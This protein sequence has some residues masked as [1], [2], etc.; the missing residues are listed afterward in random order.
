MRS[1][2]TA[3][4]GRRDPFKLNWRISRALTRGDRR[5]SA[6]DRRH[7]PQSWAKMGMRVGAHRP[8]AAT[9][10]FVELQGIHCRARY[11]R[12]AH[13]SCAVVA[14]RL[15]ARDWSGVFCDSNFR[16]SGKNKTEP[17]LSR[18]FARSLRVDRRRLRRSRPENC[19][20]CSRTDR[21]PPISLTR[22]SALSLGEFE[23]AI[24]FLCS[25]RIVLTSNCP[26]PPDRG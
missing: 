1:K 23:T 21:M 10:L 20:S 9:A 22:H 5:R 26:R 18:V 2:R 19:R 6:N 24:A 25:A 12:D 4:P 8:D 13:C 7:H 11:P 14:I 3:D 15:G 17:R 16:H